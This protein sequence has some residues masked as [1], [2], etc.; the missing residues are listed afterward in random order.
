[1]RVP[2]KKYDD[3]SEIEKR[4]FLE[5]K[6]EIIARELDKLKESE[7]GYETKYY[8]FGMIMIMKKIGRKVWLKNTK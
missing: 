7:M 4:E 8:L 3:M 1:M 6:N 2:E 5:S